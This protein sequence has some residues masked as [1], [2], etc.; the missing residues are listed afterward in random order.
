MK[1]KIKVDRKK[2]CSRD[3]ILRMLFMYEYQNGTSRT[4][5]RELGWSKSKT[6]DMYRECK[7]AGLTYEDAKVMSG[8][9]LWR[10][11]GKSKEEGADKVKVPD[12]Y[13]EWVCRELHSSKRKTLFYIWTE[14]YSKEHPDGLGYSQFCR[15]YNSWL[16]TASIE[17]ILPQER[18]PGREAFI[19]WVG[20]TIPMLDNNTASQRRAYFFIATIGD[21]S[22]PFVEAFLR[23]DQKCWT[24]AHIDMV[25]FYGGVPRL[26]VPDNTKTAVTYANLYDP[27]LNHA[28][29]ELARHYEVGITPARVRS[30]NDKATV[31]SGVK[32]VETW[33]LTW[34]QDTGK[35]YQDIDELNRDIRKRMAELVEKPFQKRAGSRKSVFEELDKPALRPLPRDEFLF[36]DTVTR[37]SLPANWHFEVKEGKNTFYYS[38]PYNYAGRPGYAHVYP[39]KVEIYVN[40][41]GRVAMHQ[42]RFTGKRYVTQIE[43]A[44]LN[45]QERMKF[46]KR[47]GKYYR[48]KAARIG[49]NTARVVGAILEAGPVEEQGYKSCDGLLRI[50]ETYGDFALEKACGRALE[51]GRPNYT[52]VNYFLDKKAGA[53]GDLIV[54]PYEKTHENLRTE[55]WR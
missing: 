7:E 36:F 27:K 34:L 39:K 49:E 48:A 31:E 20:D 11:L 47:T 46:N 25:E 12:S 41:V 54:P 4:V 18:I 45:Q 22:F 13:W 5:A 8:E 52:G 43:H 26:F 53:G 51:A 14:S 21:S 50:A 15:R 23:M 19:D 10:V 16:E 9:E 37:K 35:I 28:Y 29:Q 2:E 6:A 1:V 24:Q 32:W 44:P 38:F 55:G 40:G 3:E 30:P 42:R 17:I 33:L